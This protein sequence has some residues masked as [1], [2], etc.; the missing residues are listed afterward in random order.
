MYYDMLVA[1]ARRYKYDLYRK[2]N[3]VG[4]FPRH[5]R[6]GAAYNSACHF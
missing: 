2:T 5:Y 4:Q 6:G 3:K 1:I